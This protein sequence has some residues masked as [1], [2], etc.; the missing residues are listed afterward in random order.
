LAQ[1]VDPARLASLG[2]DVQVQ[3]ATS[4]VITSDGTLWTA[5]SSGSV[6][7]VSP[8]GHR[9]VKSYPLKGNDLVASDGRP[10]FIDPTTG[11][12]LVLSTAGDSRSIQLET[13]GAGSAVSGAID[14][15]YL[16]A[17]GTRSGDLDVTDV[18]D[19][20]TVGAAS[21]GDFS[22]GPVRYGPA[23]VKGRFAFVPNFTLGTVVVIR[24]DRA[25]LDVLGQ[26]PVGLHKKRRPACCH[27]GQPPG[28]QR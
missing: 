13:S 27:R 26:I 28:V 21:V 1:E 22:S 2:G 10:V 3:S 19:G 8:S 12:G 4:P 16:F 18:S 24:I 17:V 6:E 9:D 23:V 7:S 14:S 15:P 5:T 11:H 25:D 20:R